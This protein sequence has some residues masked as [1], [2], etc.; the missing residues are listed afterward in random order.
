MSSYASTTCC[1]EL[2]ACSAVLVGLA[3]TNGIN[4]PSLVPVPVGAYQ[5]LI[6]S[7][8]TVGASRIA[9]INGPNGTVRNVRVRRL[10]RST[11]L[12]VSSNMGCDLTTTS[13][14][15]EECIVID[16]VSRASFSVTNKQMQAYC[17][18]ASRV[19][20][21]PS[22][23]RT[24]LY[25]EIVEQIHNKLNGIRMDIDTKIIASLEANA[26]I[27]I[28]YGNNNPQTVYVV[29]C[30]DGSKI[31]KGIADII[32]DIE[33]N[34]VYGPPLIVGKGYFGRFNTSAQWGCCNSSG[35]NWNAMIEGAPYRYYTDTNIK[36]VVG[37]EN[38][39][40]VLAPGAVQFV[41]FNDNT[42]MGNLG[43]HGT[44]EYGVAIDS[45]T[46]GVD[47]DLVISKVNC[48]NG[49][50]APQWEITIYLNWGL[51]YIPLN[52]RSVNDPIYGS[53]GVFKYLAQCTV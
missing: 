48:V 53:N 28:T 12:D 49:T 22:A 31:E 35:L 47:Y 16:Q 3:D 40:F 10:Q 27:N 15:V 11:N 1:P 30:N 50:R 34:H 44:D 14:Y 45:Y 36:S 29:N 8:N 42:M 5:A 19:L 41:Y 20:V 17:A 7:V 52:A 32:S 38:R 13:D 23:P 43:V 21:D 26:G 33:D 24:P 37:D 9:D 25:M 39:I 4:N 6:D 46:P 51:S 2:G 18:D